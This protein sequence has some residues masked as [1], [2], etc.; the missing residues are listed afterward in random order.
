M[1]KKLTNIEVGTHENKVGFTMIYENGERE[2]ML[3]SPTVAI[4]LCDHLGKLAR[5][6]SIRIADDNVTVSMAQPQQES[7]VAFKERVGVS[8]DANIGLSNPGGM[9]DENGSKKI[10]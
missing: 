6:A 7:S 10:H 9:A 1:I 8:D 5:A 4:Q 3:F 2:H